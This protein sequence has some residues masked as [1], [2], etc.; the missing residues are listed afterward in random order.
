MAWKK[1]E[2][3]N[4]AGR[5]KG[6]KDKIDA[7]LRET[8]RSIVEEEF[9]NIPSLINELAPKDRAKFLL[10]LTKYIIPTLSSV[11]VNALVEGT[12]QTIE[13]KYKEE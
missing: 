9:A 12:V 1:G 10:D 8:I 3:G 6:A 13:V 5:P 4:P 2:S 11:D 7:A